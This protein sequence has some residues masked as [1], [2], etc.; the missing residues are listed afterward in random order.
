[1]SWLLALYEYK[2]KRLASY[3]G[4][5][6]SWGVYQIVDGKLALRISAMTPK[7]FVDLPSFEQDPQ[8]AI[9]DNFSLDA[10]V[11]STS[12]SIRIPARVKFTKAAVELPADPFVVLE[13]PAEKLPE[14][15]ARAQGTLG[16][17]CS[18]KTTGD[19]HS[20]TQRLRGEG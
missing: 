10:A 8:W 1:M 2:E 11:V 9:E 18:S 6:S 14:M 13:L 16:W 4:T 7:P 17:I 15:W 19:R 3:D 20:N 12:E 5:P